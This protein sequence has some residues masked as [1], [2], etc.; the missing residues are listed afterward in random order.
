MEL[1]LK[2][3]PRSSRNSSWK[4]VAVT[5][6]LDTVYI[7][8]GLVAEPNPSFNR[9]GYGLSW[10]D[11]R[12]RNGNTVGKFIAERTYHSGG[13]LTAG[14]KSSRSG[15]KYDERVIFSTDI[16]TANAIDASINAQVLEG[17][18]ANT[19]QFVAKSAVVAQAGNQPTEVTETP[20]TDV[21]AAQEQPKNKKNRQ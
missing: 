15:Q 6:V 17:I 16:A 21:P 7:D 4:G 11:D 5:M 20:V 14:P 8:C 2:L 13:R 18:K 19:L 10:H 12:D 9:N 3:Y 1:S